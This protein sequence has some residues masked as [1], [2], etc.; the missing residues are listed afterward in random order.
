M[1]GAGHRNVRFR[2]PEGEYKIRAQE[3]A[4]YEE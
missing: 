3:G 1:R 2:C 4:N